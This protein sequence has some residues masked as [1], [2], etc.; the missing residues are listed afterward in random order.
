MDSRYYPPTTMDQLEESCKSQ[1]QGLK[2]IKEKIKTAPALVK[3]GLA[4]FVL[5][6]QRHFK[7][8]CTDL[9]SDKSQQFVKE[10]RCIMDKKLTNYSK[11]DI[12]MANT[13]VELVK[14]NFDDAAKELKYLC[15]AAIKFRKVSSST[16][17]FSF[18]LT[19]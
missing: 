12:D 19:I 10:L 4:T 8:I 7:K 16:S 11:L 17:A 6:R 5:G 15:C 2:C 18:A 9:N 13:I 14:K 3:S 1:A